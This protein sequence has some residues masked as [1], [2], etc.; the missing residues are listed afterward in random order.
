MGVRAHRICGI[1]WRGDKGGEHCRHRVRAVG[2]ESPSAAA[3]G[4]S[5]DILLHCQLVHEGH[6]RRSYGHQR[7]ALP[8]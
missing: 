7:N 3:W 1:R 6:L 5:D 2:A 4:G 8:L